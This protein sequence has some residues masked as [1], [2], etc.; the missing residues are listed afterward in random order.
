MFSRA[1]YKILILYLFYTY[2]NY[3]EIN[4]EL[5][6]Y[7]NS[8]LD[9]QHIEEIFE[10]RKFQKKARKELLTFIESEKL[11]RTN[12]ISSNIDLFFK[13]SNNPSKLYWKM[14]LARFLNL[15]EKDSSKLNFP[16]DKL[17]F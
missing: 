4:D 8:F 5:K 10:E 15:E 14:H 3:D 16:L 6:E 1:L 2:N 17:N 13:A 7:V 9:E 12:Q 11:R